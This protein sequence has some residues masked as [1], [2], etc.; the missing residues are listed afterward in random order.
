MSDKNFD[1]QTLLDLGSHLR[2]LGYSFT[3]V[4]PAT[5]QR[6]IR[7]SRKISSPPLQRL[8]GWS[9]WVDQD[10]VDAAVLDLLV[11]SNLAVIESSMVKSQVRVSSLDELLFF[12]SAFPTTEEDSIFFG[13]D[14]YRFV[15]FLK[16]NIR[17]HKKIVDIG[18]GSGVGGIALAHFFE[19]S[20]E[21]CDEI[22]MTDINS[23]ALL[24]ASVNASINSKEESTSRFQFI[25]SHLFQKIPRG[26]DLVIAN[27]PFIM[28]PQGR[29]YRDGGS[30]F[31]I[32]I[33][34]KI[35]EEA[36]QYLP[37][38]GQLA[39]YTGTSVVSGEDIF[40]KEIHR[41]K[42]DRNLSFNYQELDPDIFGEELDEPNYERVERIAAVGLV[43]TKK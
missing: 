28:D 43:L 42:S 8:F 25:Q 5:H 41:F 32:D 4:T 22:L 38:G 34:L 21:R 20:G 23:K 16:N 12:H 7:R 30:H 18:T 35:I 31:G 11:K 14:S 3:T 13:P 26:A 40:L 24:F 27:P 1:L 19:K 36:L 33:S 6:V 9:D 39:L 37:A 29:A 2:R 15:Q 10:L 17:P